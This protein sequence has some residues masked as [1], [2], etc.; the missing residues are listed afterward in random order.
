[1]AVAI[2]ESL[3]VSYSNRHRKHIAGD[4][5]TFFTNISELMGL[6]MDLTTTIYD[7]TVFFP[8]SVD[9]LDRYNLDY[10]CNGSKS[11]I[12]ACKEKNVNPKIV[13]EEIQNTE[14]SSKSLNR[15]L[16]DWSAEFLTDVILR[17]YCDLRTRLPD[18]RNLLEDCLEKST[19]AEFHKIHKVFTCFNDLATAVSKHSA[20]EET[21]L[22]R[23]LESL[24]KSQWLE[25][26]LME[27]E[28]EHQ[29]I[30]S[31][32]NKLRQVTWNYDATDLLSP[33]AGLTI[34]MLQQFDKE[35]SQRLHLENNILFPK[36]KNTAT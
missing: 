35:L 25:F 7:L 23:T 13:W 14:Y 8:H 22:L 3:I 20:S 24:R 9:I 34:I 6:R 16:K 32:V 5:V 4:I 33:N 27:L 2:E 30:G 21:A 10:Y 18:I 15:S 17:H 31:L 11:F 29:H 19:N 26:P 36:L 1:M 12:D 28:Q